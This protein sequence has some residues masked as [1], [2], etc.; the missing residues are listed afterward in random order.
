[1]TQIF[2]GEGLGL[3]G[4]SLGHLGVYGPKGL[5]A[6]GQGGESVYVNAA[7]GNFLLRQSDGFL[8]SSG[9]GFELIQSYNS[10]GEGG[11]AWCF[12]TQTHL[13]FNGAVNSVGSV[14]TR[15]DED[16]HSSRFVFNTTKGCYLAEDGSI[17]SLSFSNNRWTYRENSS[18]SS[19]AYNDCGQLMNMTDRNGHLLQ[20]FYQDGQ[21]ER[22]SDNSG[23][24]SIEWIFQQGLL[25]DIRV[26]SE[27]K[28]VHHLHY[29]YDEKHRLQKISRD[30][31]GG[32]SYWV[33]YDYAGDSNRITTI[34]QADGTA[35]FIDYDSEGRVKQLI[36]G[37]GRVTHY[38]YFQGKTIVTNSLGEAWAYLYDEQGRLTGI[39]G[40][41]NTHVRYLYEGLHLA[42]IHQGSLHWF[43]RYNESGDC[44][45]LEEPTGQ[46]RTRTYDSEHRLLTE[47]SYQAFDG[48]HHPIKPKTSRFVY[49][50]RGLLRFKVASDGSVTEYRYNAEGQCLTSRT[51]LC[52]GFDLNQL[53]IEQD[54]VLNDMINWVN[55]QNPQAI[56]LSAYHY[57]W[58][59]QLD[60]EIRYMAIDANGEGQSDKALHT[61]FTMTQQVGWWKNRLLLPEVL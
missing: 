38:E 48:S 17:A 51:Y 14:V 35:L 24:Q 9:L 52:T 30:L 29:D 41:E 23:K 6:L 46:I 43:F 11:G 20:F 61:V 37:E 8:A 10:R 25:Q 47:T 32:K 55:H 4:S 1:M 18:A 13:L 21:L 40:P 53:S 28:T 39:D 22:I 19:Y 2:T 16:N 27:G 50:E 34:R 60:E 58:R 33:T 36:D 12:N 31:G 42:A 56:S 44:I 49:D 7:N 59:G 57:D 15:V 54:L 5:A 3:K 45:Y 26:M